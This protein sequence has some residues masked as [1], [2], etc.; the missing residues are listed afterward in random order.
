MWNNVRELA[1]ILV[2]LA[3]VWAV[4]IAIILL[5]SSCALFEST[6][7]HYVEADRL[8]VKAVAPLARDY[9]YLDIELDPVAKNDRLKQLADWKHDVEVALADPDGVF[10]KDYIARMRGHYD[11]IAP[12]Y[13]DYVKHD[14]AIDDQDRESRLDTIAVWELY[15]RQAELELADKRG[16]PDG[17]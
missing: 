6:A 5:T 10:G 16:P 17:N 2:P 9:L 13:T 7:P 1:K 14:G 12:W 8:Q 11:G 15:I 4:I 3:L